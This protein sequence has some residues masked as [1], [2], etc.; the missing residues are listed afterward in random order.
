M[1]E[2]ICSELRTSQAL[3]ISARVALKI[4]WR[5]G[6]EGVKLDTGDHRVHQYIQIMLE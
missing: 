6:I 1:V 4:F 5:L 3:H 2:N